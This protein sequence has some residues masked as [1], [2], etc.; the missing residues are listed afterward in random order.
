MNCDSA[1]D[2]VGHRPSIGLAKLGNRFVDVDPWRGSYAGLCLVHVVPTTLTKLKLAWINTFKLVDHA[3][4]DQ[5]IAITHF[6]EWSDAL[7]VEIVADATAAP[8]DSFCLRMGSQM[9]ETLDS[10]RINPAG[11]WIESA[12]KWPVWMDATPFF[13]EEDASAIVLVAHAQNGA[14]SLGMPGDELRCRHA[15]T[16]R[17]PQDFIRADADRLVVT[18]SRAG[19]A[20]IGERA[21]A[22]QRELDFSERISVRH[23]LHSDGALCAIGPPEATRRAY[24]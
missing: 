4:V 2:I 15:E 10:I 14:A 6:E 11:K 16:S 22:E 3:L 12:G 18:A 1:L 7:F 9:S 23:D 20:P 24:L 8:I 21:V 19:V 5:S 13:I 17:K